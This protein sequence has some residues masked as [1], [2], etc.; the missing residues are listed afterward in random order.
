MV[1]ETP[2]SG[3]CR[4]VDWLL[5]ARSA[6]LLQTPGCKLDSAERVGVRFVGAGEVARGLGGNVNGVRGDLTVISNKVE[7][8][9]R[10]E[11]KTSG[12][13]KVI[14][15][16]SWGTETLVDWE[17]FCFPQRGYVHA[18]VGDLG[19]LVRSKNRKW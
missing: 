11:L 8:V 17:R 5:I 15:T 19:R 1:W 16:A 13:G 14:V 10:V 7:R 6:P 2:L 9:E 12:R 3:A 4:R 18:F